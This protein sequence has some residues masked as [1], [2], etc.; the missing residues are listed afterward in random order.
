MVASTARRGR[1]RAR[2]IEQPLKSWRGRPAGAHQV[3]HQHL[4][5]G[6]GVAEP[7]SIDLGDRLVPAQLAVVGQSGEQ[8][9]GQRLGVGG[10]E[11][12]RVAVDRIGPTERLDAEAA[13]IHELAAVEFRFI[14]RLIGILR[15]ALDVLGAATGRLEIADRVHPRRTSRV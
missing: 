6:R 12:Q 9:R 15:T 8:Q 14:A 4:A 5:R 1:R 2:E 11:E 3:A 13:G 10:G 7:E